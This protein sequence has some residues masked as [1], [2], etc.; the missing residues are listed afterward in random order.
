[1]AENNPVIPAGKLSL[2][3]LK[4]ARCFSE[5]KHVRLLPISNQYQLLLGETISKGCKPKCFLGNHLPTWLKITPIKAVKSEPATGCKK[6]T[7]LA[8]LPA[9][10]PAG[11]CAR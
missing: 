9:K 1:L 5:K 7:N 6:T 11:G 2:P 3:F 10:P 4:A 8:T